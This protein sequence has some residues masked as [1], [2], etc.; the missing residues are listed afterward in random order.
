MRAWKLMVKGPKDIIMG[1][2]DA[3]RAA[4]PAYLIWK[5]LDRPRQWQPRQWNIFREDAEAFDAKAAREAGWQPWELWGC[6]RYAPY[7][8]IG[9]L[10]LVPMINGA[11]ITC[12][13]ETEAT[14]A[15]GLKFR[16]KPKML[17]GITSLW[18]IEG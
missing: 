5:R 1:D 10:G 3:F 12:I 8:R 9:H 7:H 6:D 14:F 11:T 2:L 18:E 15:T 17:A 16:R 4:V 13:T